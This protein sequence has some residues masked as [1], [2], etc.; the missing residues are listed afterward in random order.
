[1]PKQSRMLLL[2]ADLVAFEHTFPSSKII[3]LSTDTTE[4]KA[5]SLWPRY[6]I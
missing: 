1:M 3:I 4:L 6:L 5:F 2:K